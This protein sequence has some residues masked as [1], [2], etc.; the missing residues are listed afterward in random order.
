[1]KTL[2][3]AITTALILVSATSLAA[4]PERAS[5]D[6]TVIDAKKTPGEID[7]KLDHLKDVLERSF[8][9]Y[10]S[11]RQVNRAKFSASQGET[12]TMTLVASQ[13]LKVTLNAGGAKGFLKVHLVS[14]DLKATVDVKNGGLFFQAIRGPEGAALVMAIRATRL[15][16]DRAR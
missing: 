10:K 11:F 14:G 12:H 7:P 8:K 1:V 13:K 9:G 6:V 15:V 3:L 16:A 2:A 5:F 4:E